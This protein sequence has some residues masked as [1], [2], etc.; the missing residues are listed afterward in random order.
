MLRSAVCNGF[1]VLHHSEV[2]L[3]CCPVKWCQA[4]FIPRLLVSPLSTHVL[5]RRK[6]TIE[7]CRYPTIPT[8]C[9]QF[10]LRSLHHSLHNVQLSSFAGLNE[11]ITMVQVLGLVTATLG[12]SQVQLSAPRIDVSHEEHPAQ[13]L[14]GDV[15]LLNSGA[16]WCAYWRRLRYQCALLGLL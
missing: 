10:H 11:A 2:T 13:G 5:H 14:L 12:V 1:E 16:A 9:L 7:C 15:N 6:A 4:T 3:E 8:P